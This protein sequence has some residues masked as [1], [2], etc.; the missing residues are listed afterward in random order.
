MILSQIFLFIIFSLVSILSFS[1]LGQLINK[2]KSEDLLNNFFFGLIVV[3]FIITLIHF[4][5][6]INL[7][8]SAIIVIAGLLINLRH[9]FFSRTKIN[10]N[11][12]TYILIFIILIPIYISQKY[13]EDFGYYHLPYIINVINEKIIF[14]LANIN[15][16]F[17]HNSLWLNIMP[18]FYFKDNYNFVT[19]PTFLI[20]VIFIIFSI[21]QIINQHKQKM[22]SLFLIIT[23]F[24]L[25]L[26]FTRL[27]EFGN[28]IPSLIFSSLALYNFFRF[29]EETDLDKKKD[30][31]FKNFC[32]TSFAILIKFSAIPVILPT[33]YLFL[34]NHK[35]LIHEIFKKNF[36]FIYFLGILFFIQQFI[37]TGCFIFPSSISCLNV[38]W[39]DQNFLDSKY[40]LELVNKGYFATAKD[41]LS[42]QEYLSNYKWL[43]YWFERNLIGFSEHIGTMAI[44]IIIFLLFLKKEKNQN[45]I[46]HSKTVFFP[47]FIIIGFV[48]W[49]EFSP[50][51]RFGIIYF[52]STIFLLSFLFYEKK[53]FSKRIFLSFIT[54]FLI[55]NL[56]KNIDRLSNEK[57][58]Y[59]GIKKIQNF[60]ML[61]TLYD[62]NEIQIFQPDI[63][64]NAKKGNGWQGRLCWDIDFICTKNKVIIEKKNSYLFV[65]RSDN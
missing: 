62:E 39:F 52:L 37:Y 29:L 55:F 23:I 15:R 28:D 18:V 12:L 20:Y 21:N 32:F 61:N 26:K 8:V 48:F 13:H 54:I 59:I 5:Y 3:S 50:V 34:K 14:G 24:Y 60:S 33:I 2:N 40:K 31:F 43:S 57:R 53:I 6:K 1:G 64:S 56:T 46:K 17:V 4:F 35:I 42:E 51:Y 45:L 63:N 30:Y 49:L 7:F 65:K 22:S 9:I 38:S 27:S 47:F 10:N 36:I 44:P 11:Y 19:L 41:T 25:I 16:A 58:I